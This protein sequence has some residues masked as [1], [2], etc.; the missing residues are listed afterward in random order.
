[1]NRERWCRIARVVIGAVLIGLTL[2]HQI[3]GWGWLGVLPLVSG[4]LG[5]CPACSLGG[6]ASGGGECS[7]KK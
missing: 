3:G 2:T 5:I 7:M 6:C 1:M 4:L